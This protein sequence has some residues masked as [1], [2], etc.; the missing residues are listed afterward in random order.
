MVLRCRL[1]Q[2]IELRER[3]GFSKVVCSHATAACSQAGAGL[4][5]R[6][7]QARQADKRARL[8]TSLS[9]L[10]VRPETEPLQRG[11]GHRR[12]G[13]MNLPDRRGCERAQVK[14]LESTIPAFSPGF[15]E[16]SKEAA[17]WH[18]MRARAQLGRNRGEFSGGDHRYPRYELTDFHR[19]AAHAGKFGIA[20]HCP[21][22]RRCPA[23][24]QACRWPPLAPW[25]PPHRYRWY[26]PS[27]TN[28][29]SRPAPCRRL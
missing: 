15:V 9:M 26:S 7:H 4:R 14:A 1:Q 19:S 3:I 2:A 22:S 27:R 20:R 8:P 5:T 16:H 29:F 23:D 28:R 24:R 18:G 21:G 6:W 10:S 13:T 25:R 17:W 12:N 11:L